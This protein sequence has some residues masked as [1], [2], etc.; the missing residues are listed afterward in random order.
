MNKILS[1]ALLLLCGMCL[2]TACEDDRD[3]NPVLTQPS[4]F[5]LNEPAYA[6]DG[7]IDLAH[8]LSVN[9]SWSQPQFTDNNAPLVV[10][11]EL[12]V[13]PTGK[14]TTS[15][16]QQDADETGQLVA[17]YA[18]LETTTTHCKVAA[19]A[20]EFAKAL[21][22]A[23]HFEE[24]AVPATQDVY[25]R[26]KATVPS[27][28]PVYSNVVKINVVPE[29][30][31]LKNAP[32]EMWYLIGECIGDGKWTN[33]AAAIG[34]S[35]Y[36]MS[37]TEGEQYDKK[38]GQGKLTFTGYF[39]AGKGFK[40]ISTPGDW[41]H[42]HQWGT[43]ADGSFVKD[44]SGSSNISVAE[45]GYYTLTLD[46]KANTLTFAKADITPTVYD[47]IGVSGDFNSWGDPGDAMTAV[48]TTAEF[49]GHNHMW[50]YTL[51]ASAGATTLKFMTAGW[52]ANWGASAFPNGIG[53]SNGANIPV[54]QGK[55]I[56]TFNDIDGSYTF[57]AAE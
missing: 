19:S 5:V 34:T 53:V 28:Q 12:Q 14:F 21:Q 37:I 22:Q 40:L 41:N 46:T 10:T 9:F 39:P 6:A 11:Y 47:A 4:T 31:V 3:S 51:D 24:D 23:A 36:P 49:A 52:A 26:V 30:V 45:A 35:L 54:S 2:L 27:L 32:V 16:A 18:T 43:S 17:D 20:S 29:Y 1:I 25:V 50:S 7:G 55:W 42:T 33:S 56:V 44:D 38:T 57:T 8:S 13:S 15:F 48:N